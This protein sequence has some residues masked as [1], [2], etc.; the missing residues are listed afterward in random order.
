MRCIL[1]FNHQAGIPNFDLLVLSIVHTWRSGVRKKKV[2]YGLEPHSGE[3]TIECG[4]NYQLL[5]VIYWSSPIGNT[6]LQST[7]TSYGQWRQNWLVALPT[8]HRAVPPELHVFHSVN[9]GD[10]SQ[11]LLQQPWLEHAP[12]GM[13]GQRTAG[14]ATQ[15]KDVSDIK[16]IFLMSTY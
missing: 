11:D 1:I 13:P 5:S 6:L 9:A 3:S 7:T 2:F 12:I 16:I 10:K 8:L 14:V 15:G 4:A